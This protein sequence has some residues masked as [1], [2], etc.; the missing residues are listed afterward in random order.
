[1][2]GRLLRDGV[3]TD[4]Y[5]SM[6]KGVIHVKKL[7][8]SAIAASFLLGVVGAGFAAPGQDKDKTHKTTKGQVVS[9]M[10]KGHGKMV[11]AKGHGKVAKGAKKKWHGK[12]AAA[13][14]HGKPIKK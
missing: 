9:A 14:G 11:G 4:L 1:L 5:F 6:D 10:K 8:A 13:K 3:A 7:L 2:C 12:M